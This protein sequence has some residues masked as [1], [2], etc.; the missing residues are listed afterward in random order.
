MTYDP[1][2]PL[3]QS[4]LAT[5]QARGWVYAA[6]TAGVAVLLEAGP[7]P[8]GTIFDLLVTSYSPIAVC[9]PGTFN[10]SEKLGIRTGPAPFADFRDAPAVLALDSNWTRAGL[11]RS[12]CVPC[13]AGYATSIY[14][15]TTC[16]KC[17]AG[18]FQPTDHATACA[19]C[20][21]GTYQPITGATT[22]IMCPTDKVSTVT[23]SSGAMSAT[24]CFA[25]R[26]DI[27]RV[28]IVGLRLEVTVS[29]SLWPPT[30]AGIAD[31]VA[32]FREPTS[33]SPRQLAWAYTSAAGL[34]IS[35]QMHFLAS[36]SSAT[37]CNAHE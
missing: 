12:E 11:L 29:W 31:I 33:G 28:W 3:V 21:I 19:E 36:I 23:V 9:Q 26:V 35:H 17:T 32:I 4:A 27:E 25:A 22:C 14:A 6:A 37:H 10:M 24:A 18:R 7:L 20:P 16:V 1:S 30:H 15:A 13:S 34:V 8:A 5:P 2:T